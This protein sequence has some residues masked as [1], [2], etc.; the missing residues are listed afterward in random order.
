MSN[1]SKNEKNIQCG[2]CNVLHEVKSNGFTEVA[3]YSGV[4]FRN[5]L[6][7]SF[8]EACED[9]WPEGFHP[10]QD[11][12]SLF[13]RMSMAESALTEIWAHHIDGEGGHNV[14][15]ILQYYEKAYGLNIKPKA[16]E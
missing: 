11:L 14:T 3:W 4:D 1:D 13:E 7:V 16:S 2:N 12:D 8:C 10:W 15:E 9:E 5:Q 6:L